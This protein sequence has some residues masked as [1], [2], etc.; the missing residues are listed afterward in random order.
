MMLR[1]VDPRDGDAANCTCRAGNGTGGWIRGADDLHAWPLGPRPLR[2]RCDG[3][4][5]RLPS[6]NRLARDRPLCE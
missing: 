1:S 3:V 5:R 4:R 6:R 2:Q